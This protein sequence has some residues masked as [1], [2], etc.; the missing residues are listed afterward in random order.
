MR[1]LLEVLRQDFKEPMTMSFSSADLSDSLLPQLESGL[2]KRTEEY[3]FPCVSR[4]KHC[5]SSN[6]DAVPLMNS[7]P[8][9]SPG[10]TASRLTTEEGDNQEQGFP[11]FSEH[12]SSNEEKEDELL[13]ATGDVARNDEDAFDHNQNT[14]DSQEEELSQDQDEAGS[15]KQ[16]KEVEDLG[17]RLSESLHVTSSNHT[18]IDEEQHTDTMSSL[19]DDEF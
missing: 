1:H 15:E 8:L 14:T 3:L 17:G 5:D 12:V 10:R 2:S 19:S 11:G 4:S 13:T 6:I 9:C 7:T 18:G 16:S